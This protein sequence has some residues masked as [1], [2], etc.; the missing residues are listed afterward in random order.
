[1]LTVRQARHGRD[2]GRA[3]VP[4][5]SP[6]W[7]LGAGLAADH[8]ACVTAGEGEREVEGYQPDRDDGGVHEVVDPRVYPDGFKESA[9]F[10]KEDHPGHRRAQNPRVQ[11]THKPGGEG[12]SDDATDEECGDYSERYLREA[13]REQEPKAGA[14]GYDELARVYGTHDLARLHASATEKGRCGDGAPTSSAGRVQ[15][16][17]YEAEGGE[18]PPRDGPLRDQVAHLEREADQDIDAEAEEEDRHDRLGRLGRDGAQDHR[19]EEGTNAS[20]SGHPPD[21]APVHVTEPPVREPRRQRGAY[22]RKV[23]R[24]RGSGRCDPHRK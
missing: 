10:G 17:C 13:Q 1:M 9:G 4:A 12:R 5:R 20:R 3:P 11:V 2:V 16:P 18:K 23:H 7:L 19:S 6:D 21:L 8:R 15:K 24:R 14:D 22:L